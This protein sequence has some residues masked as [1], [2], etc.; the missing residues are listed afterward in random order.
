MGA[1]RRGPRP[2]PDLPA[3]LAA[4]RAAGPDLSEAALLLE[5][6]VAAA[7]QE[8]P[9]LGSAPEAGA[10]LAFLRLAL[11][12]DGAAEASA[13]FRLLP[14]AALPPSAEIWRS[15]LA[16]HPELALDL[17]WIA[18]AAARVPEALRG[19]HRAVSPPPL[20]GAAFARLADSLAT[21]VAA[22]AASWPENRPLR[23]L[24]IGATGDT[25]AR[26][27][28]AALAP[29]GRRV[30]YVAAG[31]TRPAVPAGAEAVAWD[32]RSQP[33]PLAADLVIGLA[34][35]ARLRAGTS[36]APALRAAL[37]EGGA[38]LLAEPL[39]GRVWTFVCGQDP[40]W[41]IGLGADPAGGSEGGALPDAA[42]WQS[43]LGEAGFRATAA[44]PLRCAPWPAVLIGAE[45]P[46][47]PVTVHP[48]TPRTLLLADPAMAAL[49]E[50]LEARLARG[51]AV[52]R[53]GFEVLAPK[54]MAGARVVVLAAPDDLAEGSERLVRLADAAAGSATGFVLVTAGDT[55]EA[56]ALR[57]LMRV[58]A[59]EMPA[60]RPRRIELDAAMPPGLPQRLA[61]ELDATD[62]EAEVILAASGRLVPRLTRGLDRPPAAGSP[63]LGIAQPGRLGT[64]RWESAETHKPGPGEVAIR[65]EAAGLNF[66]DLMWAQG[67]LPEEVLEA[68]FAGPSLGME[69]AGVVE[70]AGPGVAL[71]PGARVFGVAPAALAA[72]A[73]TRVEALVPLPDS[74][75][76]EEAAT[77]PVAFLTAV[78]ALE[79]CARLQPEETVLIHGGAGAV[80]L[81]ALQVAQAIGARVAMTAGTPAKRAFLRAAGAELVLDSRD[82]GF[83]DVL[84][85]T[86][87]EG[88]D[89]VLNSLAGEA[90]ERS[91]ELVKPFGRFVELGKRDFVENRRAPLRPLRR[92]ASYFA[93]D[94][95]ELPRA[96]PGQAARLLAGIRERLRDGTFGPLPFAVFEADAVEGAFRTLQASAHIGKLV[97]RPPAPRVAVPA[98]PWLPAEDHVVVVT[99]GTRGFG[100]EA[101]KWLA[102]QGVRHLAL[103]GRNVLE[104]AAALRDLAALGAQAAIHACDVGD[105]GQLEATLGRI[106][107]ARPIGGVV[108]AAGVLDDGAALSL[109]AARFRRVLAPKLAAAQLDRLTRDDPVSLF[110]LFGSATTVFGNPGQGNYVAANAALEAVARRRRAAERPAL[111]V[112]WGPISDAG[113]L[114]GDARKAELLQRRLGAA[115]MPAATALDALPSL[116][117]SPHPVVILARLGEG[118]LA[119]PIMAEPMLA[120]LSAAE[121]PADAGDLRARLAALPREEAEALLLRLVQEEIGRILRLPAEAVGADAAVAGLGLDS[122]GALELRGALE[123]R[124]ARQVPIAGLSE[125]LTVAA[126]T[127][128]IAAAV[129]A[130]EGAEEATVSVLMESFEPTQ[131][132]RAAE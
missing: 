38:L 125:E 115:P 73:I 48:A 112:A 127:R 49:A 76:F 13:G 6:H 131:A 128:Q 4:G 84:R 5:A 72:R 98:V 20:A 119:L 64:L 126:L 32:P 59:N 28:L 23:I 82:P 51:G 16:E 130:P 132:I 70:A 97:I 21:A 2:P 110:L 25:L 80:G 35:S 89:V 17:A 3:A 34:P 18:E 40:G 33:P 114:A 102:R 19:G 50:A 83:S 62:G 124:L 39:P 103:L 104:H 107:L 120:G 55:P 52:E 27:V 43:R 129:L 116:L 108:H 63:R 95:D 47:P 56:A 90:M 60:L 118:R 93:V 122:L 78:H 65:I 105:P 66:R 77:I 91:L 87:P 42:L 41:W 121:R 75:S 68:G 85:A 58:L 101:A 88:V 15:V 22:F 71:R 67:L 45:A 26:P 86:W 100:L 106:R 12:E 54:R 9:L 109:D 10:Y 1:G 111:C 96:R 36:L 44:E 79:E 8:A 24:E 123:A 53:L 29:F 81:A 46:P 37:A 31:E 92:N 11:V 74:L 14:E 117:A 30:R 7:A 57:G 99:G 94:V 69:C 113:M 61:A